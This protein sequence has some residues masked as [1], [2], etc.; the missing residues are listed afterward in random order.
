MP[1]NL[2]LVLQ[3]HCLLSQ[4]GNE[5]PENTSKESLLRSPESTVAK[6]QLTE[7]VVELQSHYSQKLLPLCALTQTTKGSEVLL[8]VLMK[9]RWV[10]VQISELLQ[11]LMPGYPLMVSVLQL[12]AQDA[13]PNTTPKGCLQ[14]LPLLSTPPSTSS[15]PS[16]MTA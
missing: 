5:T 2:T 8:L 4:E 12:R 1:P 14:N 6:L 3:P 10:L 16:P 7:S 15:Y 11:K 9:L 13:K